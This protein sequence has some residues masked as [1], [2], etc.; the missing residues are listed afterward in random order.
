MRRAIQLARNGVMG[1][2]PNPM[3]GAVIVCDDRIIGEGYHRKCGGPHAEVNA[4]NS[5]RQPELLPESTIYVTLEPCSHYGKT[6]PCAQLLI[7]KKVRRVVVGCGDPNEKV[8]GQGIK[9]LRDAGI[10]VKVGVLEQECLALNPK[11]MTRHT[12]NR[13]YIIL[14]WAQSSDGYIDRVREAGDGQPPVM[15]S[16]PI[17]QAA[18]HK[19]RAECDAILVGARTAYLD[20][21]SLSTRAWDGSH[22]LRLVLD[23]RASLPSGLKVFD[24][25]LP[26]RVYVIEDIQPLYFDQVDVVQLSD[27]YI[28]EQIM[29]D[30]VNQRVQSLIVEG[31]LH[32]L[33]RFIDAGLWDE[34]RVEIAPIS[35]ENGVPAPQLKEAELLK[36]TH[37]DG[38]IIQLFRRKV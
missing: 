4:V 1:A 31:G 35:L 33:Q 2:A 12:K 6:P 22:P 14:K 11:F 7:D 23:L 16:T 27:E 15:F 24:G 32:T 20:N 36:S 17:T 3:V 26:T 5:V 9:M 34:C 19:L 21:P 30:L 10:E 8:N 18:V 29:A 25:S 28:E 13:P 38:H 37:L